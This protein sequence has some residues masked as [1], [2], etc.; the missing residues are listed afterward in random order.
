[1]AWRTFKPLLSAA[2]LALAAFSVYLFFIS[3]FDAMPLGAASV[4]VFFAAWPWVDHSRPNRPLSLVRL[5]FSLM[6]AAVAVH[7]ATGGTHFPKL[8]QGR[9]ALLCEFENVLFSLGGELLAAAPFAAAAAVLF[10]I[11]F[12][13]ILRM[14]SQR[15]W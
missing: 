13:S 12:G 8:C 7:T 5:V 15:R 2:L 14:R 11:S 10:A 9:R 1:M 4:L 3:G 6:F